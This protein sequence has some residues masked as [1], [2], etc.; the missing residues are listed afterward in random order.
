MTSFRWYI[1]IICN[2]IY[3]LFLSV[4]ACARVWINIIAS[5]WREKKNGGKDAIKTGKQKKIHT[6]TTSGW[7]KL[8]IG[9]LSLFSGIIFFF[10]TRTSSQL[11]MLK[12]KEKKRKKSYKAVCLNKC[13]TTSNRIFLIVTST[14]HAE[15]CISLDKYEIVIAEYRILNARCFSKA[16]LSSTI[17]AVTHADTHRNILSYIYTHKHTFVHIYTHMY[18]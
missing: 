4:H 11:P 10:N 14:W 12:E 7:W 5:R 1:I 6:P 8:D 9:L 15:V 13:N 3:Y 16:F 18:K 2:F 17:Y